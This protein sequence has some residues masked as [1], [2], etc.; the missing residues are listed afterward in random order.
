MELHNMKFWTLFP[1]QRQHLPEHYRPE[2]LN[3]FFNARI[4]TEQ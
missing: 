2:H 3:I 4:E 1:L